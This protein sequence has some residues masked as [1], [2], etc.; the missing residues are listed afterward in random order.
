[1]PIH[2]AFVLAGVTETKYVGL[3]FTTTGVLLPK[4]AGQDV[5]MLQLSA[6]PYIEVLVDPVAEVDPPTIENTPPKLI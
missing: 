4:P 5:V 1:M 6:E 2:N 3:A